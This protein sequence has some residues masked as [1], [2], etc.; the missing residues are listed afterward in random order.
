MG[1]E[2]CNRA[3]V[4]YLQLI[5]ALWCYKSLFQKK[6]KR[7]QSGKSLNL[8]SATDTK[9][10]TTYRATI[11]EN[12]PMTSR[13]EFP[14]L[15]TQKRNQ[16]KISKGAKMQYSQDPHPRSVTYKWE[17]YQN[18]TCPPQE[19]RGLSLTFG[20]PSWGLPLGKWTPRM[21]GFEGQ[22]GLHVDNQRAIGNRDITLKGS[23]KISHTP[24]PVQKQ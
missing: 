10:T 3:S 9:I 23:H 6:K 13:K 19:A 4:C 17:E 14:Q 15:K 12:V 22:Q 21:S 16:N 11:Y 2:T 5:I 7:R 8:P 24:R 1:S 20:S 18:H